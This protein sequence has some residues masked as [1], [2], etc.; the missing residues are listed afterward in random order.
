M[1]FEDMKLADVQPTK[2]VETQKAPNR[3]F[4]RVLRSLGG[5]LPDRWFLALRHRLRFG[6]WPNLDNPSSFNEHV[7]HM[8]LTREQA[9]LRTRIADKL[10]MRDYV[11][12][13]VG[14][15][16]LSRIYQIAAKFDE[17]DWDA[18]PERFVLKSNHSCGQFM[19][20][21]KASA[22]K[23]RLKRVCDGWLSENYYPVGR[24][25]V[26]K[27]IK[28]QLYAEEV[29]V[30]TDGRLPND[31]KVHVFF[32]KV[33]FFRINENKLGEGYHEVFY[34]TNWKRLPF[35]TASYER[36]EEEKRTQIPFEWDKPA[37]L[38]EMRD[39][40]DRL[41]K[42]FRF[43]RVD[44]CDLGD[45]FIVTELTNFVAGG[46]DDYQPRS[47]DALLGG[48]LVPREAL[49]EQQANALDRLFP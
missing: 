4:N 33:R 22:D 10:G 1:G 16:Y 45:R 27:E 29:L 34:D 49:S 14:P 40:A 3:H 47:F 13:I 9:E 38:D 28:P 43:I 20:V 19:L 5:V 18:L 41:G 37:R 15:Q 39:V 26:Y 8:I 21:D 6:R 25:Y 17:L 30:R 32:G 24:E 42:P 23:E 46:N 36:D 12:E 11:A 44:Y 7:L 31:V 48:L 35:L 2:P